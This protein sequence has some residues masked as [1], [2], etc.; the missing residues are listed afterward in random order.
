LAV[1]QVTIGHIK[2]GGRLDT[3]IGG[4][5]LVLAAIAAYLQL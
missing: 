2:T 3:L 1:W 5:G 4:A